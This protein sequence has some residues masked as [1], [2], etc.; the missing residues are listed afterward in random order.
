MTNLS[1]LPD[2]LEELYSIVGKL[3]QLAPGRKFTTDG[4]LVGSIG[5]AVAAYSYGIELL[6]ASARAHDGR[7]PDGRQVQ[8]KLNQGNSVAMSHACDHLI[9]LQLDRKKG[10]AEVYNGPGGVVWDLIA[11]KKD[12]GQQRQ[13][14]LSTL[15]K[16]AADNPRS[17]IPQVHDFPCLSP[18]AL[19]AAADD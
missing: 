12:I 13:I 5:E 3:E 9:V 1:A 4:H 8:V 2:L 11:H 10:F 7:A 17:C 15:R 19:S 18:Q 16:L 6:P 14:R